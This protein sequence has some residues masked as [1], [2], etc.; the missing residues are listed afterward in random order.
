MWIPYIKTR[1]FS[2]LKERTQGPN[3][4]TRDW[5]WSTRG[6]TGLFTRRQPSEKAS[7]SPSRPLIIPSWRVRV[8][9]VIIGNMTLTRQLK[10]VQRV[11]VRFFLPARVLFF[12]FSTQIRL[13]T[14]ILREVLFFKLYTLVRLSSE[15]L[16]RVGRIFSFFSVV[17][18]KVPFSIFNSQRR[19]L[20]RKSTQVP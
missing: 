15:L 19:A 3:P 11:L 20:N 7:S 8:W 18:A 12:K 9:C 14:R 13:S 17:R 10:H 5:Q 4:T 6:R 1:E 16:R 2:L